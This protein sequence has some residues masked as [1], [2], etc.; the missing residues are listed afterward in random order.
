MLAAIVD[1]TR[2]HLARRAG[3]LLVFALLTAAC[4]AN[5]DNGTVPTSSTTSRPQPVETAQPTQLPTG[6]AT[7]PTPSGTGV[8]LAVPT[9]T[10]LPAALPTP[11]AVPA[12]VPTATAVPPSTPTPGPDCENPPG[13]RVDV[14]NVAPD[15]PDGGLV[16]HTEPGA[17]TPIVGVLQWDASNVRYL[18][19]CVPL[20]DGSEWIHIR[21]TDFEGWV[22]AGY[23]GDRR[24]PADNFAST[25]CSSQS[26]EPPA[27]DGNGPVQQEVLITDID[28]YSSPE[29]DRV[30]FEL[31]QRVDFESISLTLDEFPADLVEGISHEQSEL[32]VSFDRNI[33]VGY[34]WEHDRESW[35]DVR[36]NEQNVAISTVNRRSPAAYVG[37]GSGTAA[38]RFADSPAR[39]VV[40][41]FQSA[42]PEGHVSGPIVGSAI[43]LEPVQVDLD[44]PGVELPIVVRGFSSGFEAG[45]VFVIAP[46]DEAASSHPFDWDGSLFGPDAAGFTSEITLD[47]A[48]DEHSPGVFPFLSRTYF[49]IQITDL[50]PGAYQLVVYPTTGCGYTT[51]AGQ[52]FRVFDPARPAE[53]NPPALTFSTGPDRVVVLD[54]ERELPHGSDQPM[55]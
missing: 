8:P 45:G 10:V 44:G 7:T 30:V 37:W 19:A 42:T 39:I 14:A 35:R 27:Q 26:T 20:D 48:L 21:T 29:C 52:Q 23:T 2:C 49:E 18:G 17:S 24:Y 12:A 38:V 50:A 5:D 1:R 22:N 34:A 25:P 31:G 28:V 16:V 51:D 32:A 9:A 6:A 47:P 36:T 53:G 46:W 43:L 54:E 40:D 11:T 33:E 41:I 13:W 15:D 3:V 55:C 4:A